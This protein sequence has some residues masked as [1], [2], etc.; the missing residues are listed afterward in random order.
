MRN[1]YQQ[2]FKR[3]PAP[4]P[5]PGLLE[6]VVGRIERAEFYSFIRRRLLSY[7]LA[8]A[9]SLAAFLPMWQSLQATASHTGF[10]QF[11]LLMQSDSTA[12][13]AN[14]QDFGLSLLEALP[15][16]DIAAFLLVLLVFLWSLKH[17]TQGIA[18]L[19]PHR[20]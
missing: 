19:W 4:I 12:V 2:L 14:F 18:V 5:Q 10:W 9:A 20:V 11:V 15:A 7:V 3:L 16:V 8:F 1:D 17:I 6:A 13:L